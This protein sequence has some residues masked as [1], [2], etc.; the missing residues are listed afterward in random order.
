MSC[1][2]NEISQNDN[3]FDEKLMKLF[4]ENAWSSKSTQATLFQS[5]NNFVQVSFDTIFEYL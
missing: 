2:R 4:Q 5:K 1:K 3:F